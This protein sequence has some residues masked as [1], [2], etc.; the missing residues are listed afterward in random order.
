M[1]LPKMQ[2]TFRRPGHNGMHDQVDSFVTVSLPAV[3]FLE[4]Q[5]SLQPGRQSDPQWMIRAATPRPALRSVPKPAKIDEEAYA[6]AWKAEVPEVKSAFPRP[7]EDAPVQMV[8]ADIYR[9]VV[10]L[11][12]DKRWRTY[13]DIRVKTGIDSVSAG[14]AIAMY[15][16]ENGP[17][18]VS[19]SRTYGIHTLRFK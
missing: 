17:E 4:P 15:R 6:A 3:P 13:E 7:N 12:S 9:A 10:K 14:A 8:K 16:R 1:T 19:F 2:V 11:M 18:S 5:P